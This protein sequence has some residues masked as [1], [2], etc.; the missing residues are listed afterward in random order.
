MAQT[1]LEPSSD[2]QSGVP[3]GHHVRL[4]ALLH[5]VRRTRAASTVDGSWKTTAALF[6]KAV[7]RVEQKGQGPGPMAARLKATEKALI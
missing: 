6:G 2:F 5:E 7:P 1:G 3:L 4:P